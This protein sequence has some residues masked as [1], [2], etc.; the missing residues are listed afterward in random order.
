MVLDIIPLRT[1]NIL[2]LAVQPIPQNMA[3]FISIPSITNLELSKFK[4]ITMFG[5]ERI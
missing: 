1:S 3:F 2:A 5:G 4:V